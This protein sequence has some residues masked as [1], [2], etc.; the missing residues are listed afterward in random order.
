MVNIVNAIVA[1]IQAYA[2]GRLFGTQSAIEIYFAA[3]GLYQAMVALQ[4]SGP[5]AEIFTPMYHQLK[6][7]LGDRTAFDLL[8]VLLSWMV[9]FSI[10]FS[11]LLYFGATALISISVPGFSPE[12]TASCIKMFQVLIPLLSLQIIQSLLSNSEDLEHLLH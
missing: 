8:S 2:I 6:S 10:A 5:I 11:G 7:E 12:M 9:L 3:A 4:Q 1:L